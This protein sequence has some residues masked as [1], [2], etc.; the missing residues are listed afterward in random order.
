MKHILPLLTLATLCPLQAF[1]LTLPEGTGKAYTER[2]QDPRNIALALRL[3]A[4]ALSGDEKDAMQFLYAYMSVPDLADRSP[5][6]YLANVRASLDARAEMPWGNIVPDREWR[7]FVLPVRVNNENLD[8]SR[9]EFYKE[10]K[11]RVKG[12]SMTEAALEVNHWCHEKATYKPSDSRTS[13]PLSTVSQAIGR[14]G[15]ESTFGVAALRAVGIPARQ[16]YTPRWAHTDDNHAWVEVWTDGHWHFLGACEPEPVL[17]L[18]WFNAPAGRG[19]VMSTN[20]FGDYDGPEEVLARFPLSTRIN[21]TSN[22]APVRDV[23]VLVTDPEG[24]P[25]EGADVEF[26]IY[27]YAQYFPVVSRKT[28]TGGRASMI[29]GKGDMMIWATD[30]I[31]RALVKAASDDTIT[32]AVLEEPS[33]G[34]MARKFDIVPPKGSGRSPKV[35]P[36]MRAENDR[37]FATEDSIR[38]AYESTFC[39]EAQAR[40]IAAELGLDPDRLADILVKS[41][42]NHAK[43]AGMLRAMTS[44]QRRD[45]LEVLEVVSEKDLRDMPAEIIADQVCSPRIALPAWLCGKEVYEYILNPRV[46]AEGLT[47]W[48]SLLSDSLKVLPADALKSGATMARWTLENILNDSEGNPNKLRQSPASTL[49]RR[50]ADRIGRDIFYVTA[51]RTLGIPA[52]LDPMT[53]R[54]QWMASP[55]RW[56]DAFP[57]TSAT[58]DVS[59]LQPQKGLLKLSYEPSGFISDP[60]YYS[61]FL[62]SSIQEGRATDLDFPE[63]ATV[64]NTFAGGVELDPGE[65]MLTTGQRMADGSVL[66]LTKTFSIRSGETLALPLEIRQDDTSLQVIG[67]LDAENLYYDSASGTDKS[68]LSTAGRGYYVLG[69]I[70]P[71]HEPSAH[72]LNDISAVARELEECGRKI[73]LLF[74]DAGAKQRFANDH[75]KDIPETAVFGVDADK[76]IRRQIEASLHLEEDMMPLFVIG[77]SFNRIVYV[78][79]GYTIGLGET[80]LRNLRQL[81]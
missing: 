28:D 37:L 77:D 24:R 69:L 55:G 18:A 27:N 64:G 40:G 34:V 79:H 57:T 41:R 33:S 70:A 3:E 32:V 49:A 31:R 11:E 45:A 14:C 10:L 54:A 68:L 61:S 2:M 13:S 53:R 73:F 65:Y 46:E 62:L 43:L 7:H 81:E 59:P 4:M 76:A 15:E 67:T 29:A 25:V 6:F 9:P 23:V 38:H 74:A 1:A 75:F 12:M 5:E 22:Y 52:R 60:K 30:G 80:I 20:V 44:D 17:D 71:G 48:R 36:E 63:D 39:S 72:A 66:A 47:P 19:M 8:M 56:L 16:V 51:C 58:A 50:S 42:G 26:C 78:S 35:S 21:I